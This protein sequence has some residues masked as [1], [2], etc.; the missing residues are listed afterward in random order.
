MKTFKE[1]T[2]ELDESAEDKFAKDA[3]FSSR[4]KVIKTKSGIF[5]ATNKSGS[6]KSFT[7]EKSANKHASKKSP[8]DSGED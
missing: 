3:Y 1:F 6:T 7:S 5:L 4:G 2:E 8:W